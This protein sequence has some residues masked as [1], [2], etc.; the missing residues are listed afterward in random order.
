MDIALLKIDADEKLPFI[1]FGTSLTY[2]NS[3]NCC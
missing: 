2:S 1:V 3:T